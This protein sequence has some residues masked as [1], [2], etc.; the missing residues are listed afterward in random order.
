MS[1]QTMLR[2]DM[3]NDGKLTLTDVNAL[4]DILIGKAPIEAISVYE[5]DNTTVIGTWYAEDGTMLIF[6]EDGTTNYPGGTTYEFMP[7]LGRLLVYDATGG[8]IKTMILTKVTPEYLLEENAVNGA[9]TYY[10]NSAYV[11]A[12][13]TLN[14]SSLSLNSGTTFLLQ[15]ATAPAT[16][17]SN[18]VAWSSSDESVATVNDNGLV[19]AVASGTCTITCT[20]KDGGGASASCTVSVVQMVTSITLSHTTLVLQPDGFQKLTAT[21]LPTNANNRG[22]TWTSSDE[23]VAEVTSNGGVAAI[24]L[25]TCTI[26]CTAKDG[27]GVSATC[28]VTVDIHECVDLGLPSGTLW[29]TCN[30]GADN[31][32]DY[33]DYFAWGETE[34]KSEYNW[35]TYKYC[36]GSNIT[37]IKYCTNPI[38]GVIDN[39]T[40]LELFDDAAYMNWG[41]KWRMP[42]YEQFQELYNSSYTSTTWTTLNNVRGRLITS[43]SNNNSLFLPATGFYFNTSL[44]N[45]GAD[46][47]YWSF[48]LDTSQSI[49]ACH[50]N[51][52][53]ENVYWYCGDRCLGSSIRPVRNSVGN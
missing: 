23:S 49:S 31:P 52:S 26:T 37:M 27:S 4:L 7:V 19:T 41:S 6:R 46:G 40:E 29:A 18:Y 42:S 20:A 45:A 11:V 16:A 34:T 50:L 38:F 21:V 10:T 8:V 13:I 51:I 47:Y 15:A 24:G 22:V 33:G 39:M 3:N 48:M 32:E 17:L 36:N 35:S 28:V 14:R 9:L 25:G 43:K 1:G 12:D 2:G 44:T 5:V 30:I 53:L